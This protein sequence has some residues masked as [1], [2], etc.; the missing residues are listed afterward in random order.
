ME[1]KK[2]VPAL[3]VTLGLA[4][5]AHAAPQNTPA[6]Q[7]A[8]QPN[9][10]QMHEVNANGTPVAQDDTDQNG[11]D[12][13]DNSGNNGDDTNAGDDNSGNGG[14]SSCGGGG[15]SACGSG[16]GG[17]NNSDDSGQ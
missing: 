11:S 16:S 5:V 1:F 9:M 13:D 15:D 10:F 2:V 17:G 14:D 6:A 8:Y 7:P 3:A 4:T 12:T